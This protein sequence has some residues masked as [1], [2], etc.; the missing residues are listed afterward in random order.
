VNTPHQTDDRFAKADAPPPLSAANFSRTPL[1]RAV[2]HLECLCHDPVAARCHS[3]SLTQNLRECV[4]T[5][6]SLTLKSP[7][8]SSGK[9]SA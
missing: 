4:T 2:L 7:A 1:R 9:K 8:K 5:A 3:Q 6:N